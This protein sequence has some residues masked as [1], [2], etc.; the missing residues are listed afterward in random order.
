MPKAA[1][2]CN[3]REPDNLFPTFIQ[4]SAAAAMGNE[5]ILFFPPSRA[6]AYGCYFL[7]L[8]V[9]CIPI[10]GCFSASS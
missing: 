10:S 6:S 5:V 1:I 3:G 8:T 7:V 4:G 2:I 9:G